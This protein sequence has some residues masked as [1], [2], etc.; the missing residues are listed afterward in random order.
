[1]W[2]GGAAEEGSPA[3]ASDWAAQRLPARDRRAGGGACW[4][5]RA[6]GGDGKGEH[7]TAPIHGEDAGGDRAELVIIPSNEFT[8]W[9]KKG[10]LYS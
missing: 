9:G 3:G 2:T 6:A 1:M 10:F 7:T 8:V 4:S 5:G